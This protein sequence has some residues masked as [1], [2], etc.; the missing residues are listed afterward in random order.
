MAWRIP[1]VHMANQK[2]EILSRLRRE[3]IALE[4]RVTKDVIDCMQPKT[5]AEQQRVKL[6]SET[7]KHAVAQEQRVQRLEEHLQDRRV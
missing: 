5:D 3:A 7:T 1:A 4:D 2:A 6:L